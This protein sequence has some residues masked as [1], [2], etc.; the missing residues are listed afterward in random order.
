MKTG[1]WFDQFIFVIFVIFV[2]FLV[3]IILLG[4]CCHADYDKD[5]L[6]YDEYGLK[7]V[8]CMKCDVP[9]KKRGIRQHTL[10]DGRT[11]NVYYVKTLSNF[12]PVPYEL[13]NGS[14]TH[15]LMCKDCART[16]VDIPEERLGMA[17]QLRKGWV[18]EA[19]GARRSQK[20][21]NAIEKRMEGITVSGWHRLDN[22][23][24]RT[25]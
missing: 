10:K 23:R 24:E 7:E 6:E 18:L 11:I 21:I 4:F 2:A 16:H 8:R 5:Y 14:F 22:M 19:R 25:Q 9:I 20:E 13:S 12:T 17:S 15:I 3:N 1:F